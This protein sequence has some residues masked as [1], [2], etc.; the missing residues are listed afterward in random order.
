ML[1]RVVNIVNFRVEA[2]HQNFLVHIDEA[3]PKTLIGDD[4]RLAQVITNLLGNA[5]K[6]TPEHGSVSLSTRLVGEINDLCTIQ[7]SVIDSGI[8]ISREQQD[9]LFQSFQQAE[10]STTRKYGGTGLG[11]VISKNIVEMM[12]G[13]IWI[14]SE[15]EKG[16]TFA[17]TIQAQQKKKKKQEPFSRDVNWNNIRIMAVDDDP[18]IL[19]Y[20]NDL[21]QR[22][23]LSCDAAI[24][25]ADALTLVAR[26]GDYHVYFVDWKMPDMNGIQLARE[27]KARSPVNSV[28]IMISSFEW[29][30]IA[31]E[32]KM[33]GVDKFLSKPLFPSVI[34]DIINECLGTDQ[35]QSAEI[36]TSK[37]GQF[38]GRRILMVE[39][40]D[41]NREVVLAL[42]EPENMV[43]DCA[44]NG[45]QAVRMYTETPDKYDIILMDIQMP[46]MDG[47]EATRRIR[48][49][50]A[51]RQINDGASR[52]QIPIIAMT[53]N[54]FKEDVEKC[55]EAGMNDHIGKPLDFSEVMEKLSTYLSPAR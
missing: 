54:V 27:L 12:G 21:A 25:G 49:F 38:S 32:A 43:I 3:I 17:F 9:K 14:E 5:I 34:A 41:I 31:D 39:D 15:L 55:H 11:L 8:G 4:Q 2:K 13:V 7:I 52:R 37:E 29:A 1:Q 28:V 19:L 53:A 47:Y 40:V 36:K 30:A 16:S 50:E 51:E 23:D 33:A 45:I 22:L 10:S 46:E 20:F 42:L 24:S 35:G 44:E 26:N 6:F 18:D 48:S